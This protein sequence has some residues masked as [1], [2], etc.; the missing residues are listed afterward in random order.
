[1]IVFILE[2]LSDLF[3][4]RNTPFLSQ[5]VYIVY[6]K[7]QISLPM[8]FNNT[9]PTILTF[10]KGFTL[11]SR[12]LTFKCDILPNLLNHAVINSPNCAQ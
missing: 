5:N 12:F 9:F 11:K 3:Q 7:Q 6:Y 1:M 10:I 8:E 4:K 2:T